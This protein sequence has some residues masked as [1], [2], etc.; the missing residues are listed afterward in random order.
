MVII[1]NGGQGGVTRVT[2]NIAN[3]ISEV[4]EVVESLTG[5]DLVDMV[6]GLAKA[7]TKDNYDINDTVSDLLPKESFS[8]AE[9]LEKNA[10]DEIS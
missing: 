1:D 3:I 7:K 5:I 9:N 6:K 10:S 8:V 4:P 2:K